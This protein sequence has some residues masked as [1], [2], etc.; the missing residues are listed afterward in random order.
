MF[1]D[2][3]RIDEHQAILTLPAS[4]PPSSVASPV[5]QRNG[6]MHCTPGNDTSMK[7]RLWIVA[8]L[9]GIA[10]P[11]LQA[12]DAGWTGFHVGVNAG[13]GRH[14]ATWS[15]KDY[16]NYSYSYDLTG[17]GVVGGLQAGY[18]MEFDGLVVGIEADASGSSIRERQFNDYFSTN[19]Q[20]G[21]DWFASVRARAG[22]PV[23]NNL[24]YLTAGPAVV[25]VKSHVG[26]GYYGRW[27][28]DGVSMVMG[29][30]L[31]HKLGGNW[32]VRAELLYFSLPGGLS[33]SYSGYT[34][35]TEGELTVFRLGANYNF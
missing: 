20:T 11:V 30:G 24:L 15:D 22:V 5:L 3:R 6:T 9:A 21:V 1:I 2:Y 17:Q 31:E 32:S 14:D 29:G 33:H 23:T 25:H 7:N 28:D 35:K 10:A 16:Y 4:H 12:A 27:E 8:A 19:F 18:D 26:N 34:L 13:Y